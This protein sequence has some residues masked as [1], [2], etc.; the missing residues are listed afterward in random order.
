MLDRSEQ[1]ADY[2]SSPPYNSY[3]NDHHQIESFQSE[4]IEPTTTSSTTTTQF[5]TT[6]Y[7][8]FFEYET[9]IEPSTFAPTTTT[10]VYNTLDITADPDNPLAP[11]SALIQTY[12]EE[13][14]SGNSTL[15]TDELQYLIKVLREQ[16]NPVPADAYEAY[17]EYAEAY[18]TSI[19]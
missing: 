7:T 5:P 9:T 13:S 19:Q 11:L 17:E 1:V 4:L 2:Y 3:Q 12:Y 8:T 10:Y 15:S 6:A 14:V 16:T 18:E